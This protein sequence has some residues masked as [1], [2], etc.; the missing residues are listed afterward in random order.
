MTWTHSVLKCRYAT[1]RCLWCLKRVFQLQT[2]NRFFSCCI[3]S[4]GWFPKSEL[5][6]PTFRNAH[7]HL[8]RRCPYW[9]CSKTKVH[10][11]QR[12]G[13]VPKERIQCLKHKESLKSRLSLVGI[14]KPKPVPGGNQQLTFRH[15]ESYISDRRTATPQIGTMHPIYRTDV[16]L[17]HR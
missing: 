6:V 1:H 10:K 15:H 8:Y 4:F 16:P 5:Y 13:S 2:F 3:I 17:L 7:F 11:I 9:K 12:R 14:L